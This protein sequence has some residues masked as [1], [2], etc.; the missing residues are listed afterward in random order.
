M[1]AGDPARAL[2]IYKVL[3]QRTGPGAENAAY[4]MGKIL[5]ERLG[6]PGNAVATWR[7]YRSDHPDGILRLEADVSIIET[8]ARSGESE[9]ALVEATEF[10]R[11]HPDSERRPEVARLTGDLY[12]VRGDCRRA[13][14][15]Y[16]ITLATRRPNADA[17][18]ASYQ[19]AVCLNRLGDAGAA[20]AARGYV[21]SYPNGRFRKEAAALAGTGAQA[22]PTDGR[23]S[24]P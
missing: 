18:V 17:E 2:Q 3:A 11:R 24:R 22:L 8:L 13:V 16:Q 10:L 1:A 12:R 23:T 4:E 6:Q 19:R 20:E 15:A 21:R 7:R 14:G 5:S 9:A